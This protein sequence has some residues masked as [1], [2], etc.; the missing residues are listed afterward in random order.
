MA[1]VHVEILHAAALPEREEVG[2]R[3]L[4][5]GFEQRIVQEVSC[6]GLQLGE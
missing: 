1:H 2:G 6:A 4:L 3:R 5:F